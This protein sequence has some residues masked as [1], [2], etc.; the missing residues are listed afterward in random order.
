MS[1]SLLY[2]AFGIRGYRY[3]STRHVEGAT[4]LVIEHDP[5]RLRC[6]HCGSAD[7]VGAGQ[8]ERRFRDLPIGS[9]PTCI[10][11]AVQRLR[12]RKC[13]TVRQAKL[14]FAD[15]RVRHTRGF[16]RYALELS[17]LTTIHDAA[18]H[19]G[20]SWDT[21]KDIQKRN[22][23]QRFRHIKL[24]HLKQIAI[25]EICVGKGHRYRSADKGKDS[26]VLR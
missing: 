22:L 25:D 10:V 12:C 7:V 18:K 20:V 2:H 24:R 14:T 8:V 5:A 23:Q 16:E 13:E 6:P 3:R 11:L 26:T 21:V 9:R 1:T 15:E 4:E 19:L 17:R